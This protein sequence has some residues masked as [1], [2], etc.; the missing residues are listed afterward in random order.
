L[1]NTENIDRIKLPES[2]SNCLIIPTC[3]NTISRNEYTSGDYN[4]WVKT[5]KY[6]IRI[7]HLS[8]G[9]LDILAKLL[10]ES[11]TTG[12]TDNF[13]YDCFQK[14]IFTPVRSKDDYH[15]YVAKGLI[16]NIP[17]FFK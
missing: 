1:S 8:L 15:E 16:Y 14:Q 12:R 4:D 3:L 11:L 7:N 17:I 13:S 6:D 5:T 10:Q 2:S 9:N